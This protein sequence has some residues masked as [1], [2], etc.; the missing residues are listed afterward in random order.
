MSVLV[1][2]LTSKLAPFDLSKLKALIKSL[3]QNP[4]VGSVGVFL[5]AGIATL[6]GR[7]ISVG[8]PDLRGAMGFGFDEA[9]WI[10]T[11]YNMAQM[12]IGPFSVYL[13][14]LL[15]VRRVLLL[16]GIVFIL[17][18]ILLPLSPNLHVL[19]CLQVISGL[20]SGTFYPLTLAYA[21][22]ALPMRFVIYAVGVYSVDI[23]S[24]TSVGTALEALYV[25]HLSWHW[26]FWQS[27]VLTPV[28]LLCIYLAIPPQPARSGPKPAL[29]WRGFLYASLAL[30]FI[31]GA[32]DQ[33][34]RLDWLNSGVIVGLLLSGVFLL[35]VT[36][37]RRWQ[38]PNQLVNP[39]FLINRNTAIVASALFAF[40]FVLLGIAFLL[41][42]VL[43]VT[44]N[45]RPLQTGRVLLWLFLPMVLTGL[46]AARLMRR[47]DN[48]LV[49]ASGFA[50]IAGAALLNAQLTSS[51]SGNE[52]FIS[53]I[54]MGIGLPLT[55]TAL[56]GSIL[57]NSF[58]AGA[59]TS[60]VNLLTYSSF[61][62]CV[63]LFG[64]E[65]GT[66]LMQRLVS[67][68]EKFHSNMIGL[69]VDAGNSLTSERLSALAHAL[70]PASGSE[71]AQQRAAVTLGGQ[72]K[73]Q[74]YAL[75]YSDGYLM[76][77]LVAALAMILIAFMKPMKI[78]FDEG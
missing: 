32:L 75:A 77:A 40:R 66:A 30:S 35:V 56:V 48:R 1:S 23:L 3:D 76:I 47:F 5:G 7:V 57:Q 44:Q 13:G 18:S 63:R 45:Y 36:V 70:L 31:Y 15:G 29:S 53:Q 65:A 11:A 37:I 10:P 19:L 4:Y 12:F 78:Y 8:L 17:C 74:A 72:I 51:W 21:L 64:G 67:V 9:S 59:L 16:S 14:A 71:E 49:F 43:G 62:H 69:H 22:R 55:F 27:V 26:I 60:P 2:Q 41:P 61:I 28:M 68:R 24:A 25:E 39:I 73:L 38:S 20:S 52:F 46:V 54:V 34:E 58:D 33:G 6:N 42:A 50:I